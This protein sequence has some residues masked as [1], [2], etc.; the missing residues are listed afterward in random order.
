[1]GAALGY[2]LIEGYGGGRIIAWDEDRPI[3]V[4]E[5]LATI[6]AVAHALPDACYLINVCEDR[7]WFLVTF[8][9]ALWR[10]VPNLLPHNRTAA[11]LAD[12]RDGYPRAVFVSDQ[13]QLLAGYV[14]IDVRALAA[15]AAL[16]PRPRPHID[17]AQT[18]AIV[19]TSGS[20]GIPKPNIKSWG[21]MVEIA[22]RTARRFGLA[23]GSC[24][25]IVATVPQQHMYGLETSIMLPIQHGFVLDRGKPFYPEDVRVALERVPVPRVLITT[26][27][28]LRA[29][30]AENVSLPQL[31]LI[32]SATAPLPI[33]LAAQVEQRFGT[34]VHEIYGWSEAGSVATRRTCVERAWRVLD[35]SKL[36]R[37]ESS[38]RV[39]L[40][41]DFYP[42]PVPF[43]DLIEPVSDTEFQLV[44]RSQDII[45]VAGK[46]VSLGDL[47]TKICA[48][49]GVRDAVFYLPCEATGS[50]ARLA[51]FVV[52]PGLSSD[53]IVVPLRASLDAVFL[54]RRVIFVDRLPRNET[55]K[56]PLERLDALWKTHR[57]D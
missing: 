2:P 15:R 38:G 24:A 53:D 1:M 41:A 21:S 50:V 57:P 26:P 19:F 12:M 16:Y 39:A 55:G 23:H 54:P 18:A 25:T 44:G 42:A 7:Y 52:A 47:N 40:H 45:N 56:L 29:C 10:G 14:G 13:D 36:R 35:G 11:T 28:H 30:I 6:A 48:L 22:R 3:H 49:P 8:A 32:I 43:E 17:A 46:R 51:A 4:E 37:D 33:E 34:R 9:A 20:T 5:F 27:I 31:E